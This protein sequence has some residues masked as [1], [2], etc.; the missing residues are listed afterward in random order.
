MPQT[1]LKSP[2]PAMKSILPPP[3]TGT[4]EA[5]VNKKLFQQESK[6]KVKP[7][8]IREAL[9]GKISE[10]IEGNGNATETTS[11]A[12][13]VAGDK[14][15]LE[16]ETVGQPVETAAV[17]EKLLKK[18]PVA[19][20]ETV[21]EACDDPESYRNRLVPFYRENNPSKLDTVDATLAAFQGKEDE[22]FEKL[23]KKYNPSGIP[24]PS[25]EGPTC[26]L[27]FEFG[28]T[29]GRVE[30]KLF[31]DKT[32]LA[33]ENFRALCTGEKGIGRSTR[34]LCYRNCAM[35]RIV[36]NF[37]IQGGDF[38]KGDGTGGESIYPPNSE[39]GDMWGKFKDEIFMQHNRKGLLSMANNGANRNGSQWFIT[40]AA[41]PSLNGKHVVFGEVTKGMEFVEQI[42]KLPT[43]EKQRPLE[44]I[45]IR[46]CGEVRDGTEIR[47]SE[48]ANETS[49]GAMESTPFG[50]TACKPTSFGSTISNESPFSASK[51]TPFGSAS[52][53]KAKVSPFSFAASSTKP[54]LFGGSA[55]TKPFSFAALAATESKPSK[56]VAVK[57]PAFGFSVTSGA[58]TDQAAAS[59]TPF[60]FAARAISSDATRE[61]DD[62]SDSS[63]SSY[64]SPLPAD[65]DDET[66]VTTPFHFAAPTSMTQLSTSTVPTNSFASS[67]SLPD[68]V[69]DNAEP[70]KPFSFAAP[71]IKLQQDKAAPIMPFSFTTEATDKAPAPSFSEKTS[72]DSEA[73]KAAMGDSFSF[74]ALAINSRHTAG[75]EDELAAPIFSFSGA[76]KRLSDPALEMSMPIGASRLSLGSKETADSLLESNRLMDT[77]E[78]AANSENE[79]ESSPGGIID[80]N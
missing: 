14:K 24:P 4:R 62:T 56:D 1:E 64:S 36:P 25:G 73:G 41:L 23:E 66:R 30:V 26:F 22:L 49:C 47:A 32:P 55:A 15:L 52:S 5:A 48:R 3:P 75:A 59:T 72:H 37:V 68:A 17:H 31:A 40:L 21:E 46:D 7:N 18:K 63:D 71:T 60:G 29:E 16:K 34:P 6:V 20:S 80:E 11:D 69:A 38:T 76:S 53:N 12:A 42:S 51:S 74:A 57:S 10:E 77:G 58:S 67:K 78:K 9:R 45:V 35:H 65:S 44:R 13:T 43:D 54:F 28:A 19:D 50:L 39:H 2:P 61:S 79:Q 33:A 70:V 27:E 8:V